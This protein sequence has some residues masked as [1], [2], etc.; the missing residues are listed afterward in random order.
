MNH[1]WHFNRYD[2]G[3]PGVKR[4]VSI[5]PLDPL[6]ETSQAGCPLVHDNS[7]NKRC[8][9][10]TRSSNLINPWTP[11]G[12]MCSRRRTSRATGLLSADCSVFLDSWGLQNLGRGVQGVDNVPITGRVIVT[13]IAN[14]QHGVFHW[15]R[16]YQEIQVGNT[17]RVLGV[18]GPIRSLGL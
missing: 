14:S 18:R 4:V 7:Q 2:C 17:L 6:P 12:A 3:C 8:R 9:P 15:S 1:F 10:A 13:I 16:L 11:L 5:R